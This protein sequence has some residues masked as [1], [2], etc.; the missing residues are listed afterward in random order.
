MIFRKMTGNN[1]LRFT[2]SL[3]I[4]L[5]IIVYFHYRYNS[6]P[7]G[8]EAI[9]CLASLVLLVTTVLLLW[10]M[11]YNINTGLQQRNVT[12]GLYF[13]L[14]WTI[15]ISINNLIQPG[16]P[17]RDLLDDIIWAIIALLILTTATRFA[18]RTKSILEGV[19]SGFWSG[20]SSGAIACLTGLLYIVFGMKYILLDP[21]NIKEWNDFKATS[22]SPG[23]DVYFAYQTFTG[24]IAH[25]FVLGIIMG[26]FLGSLGG[27]IGKILRILRNQSD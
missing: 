24:A 25:L 11:R 12:L 17:F 5:V 10:K 27:L 3:S 26:L 1:I 18:F 8:T 16:L 6:W 7:V 14:L 4:I 21:L 23:M 22:N 2:I 15:E 20:L 9:G 19:R 13:G